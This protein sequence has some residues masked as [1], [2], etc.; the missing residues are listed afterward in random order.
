MCTGFQHPKQGALNETIATNDQLKN[1]YNTMNDDE[2][3]T[4][5]PKA[6]NSEDLTKKCYNL[7]PATNKGSPQ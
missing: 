2:M 6:S 5:Q 7:S 1:S 3:V 4:T